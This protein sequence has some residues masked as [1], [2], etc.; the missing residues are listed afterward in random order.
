MNR[1][2]RNNVFGVLL[3]QSVIPSMSGPVIGTNNLGTVWGSAVGVLVSWEP[4]DFGLRQANVAAA[5]AGRKQ[6]EAEVR[7]TQFEVAVATA[8][9]YLTL[10]V[11]QETERAAQGRRGSAG[12][13]LRTTNALVNSQ[14]RPG[15]DA[16]RADAELAAART[17]LIQADEI[18]GVAA[19]TVAQFVGIDAERMRCQAVHYSSRRPSGR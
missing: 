2:T 10:V 16:S 19:A 7:R 9:A 14:L 11:A 6:S 17:Q 3:P 12:I 4:F 18:A 8:D 5:S 13:V 15:A 1:A